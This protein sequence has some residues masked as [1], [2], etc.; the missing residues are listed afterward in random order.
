[1]QCVSTSGMGLLHAATAAAKPVSARG[2][3][4]RGSTGADD[5]TTAAVPGEAPPSKLRAARGCSTIRPMAGIGGNATSTFVMGLVFTLGGVGASALGAYQITHLAPSEGV[6]DAIVY[7][8]VPCVGVAMIAGGVGH[9]RLS[10]QIAKKG[11]DDSDAA[12]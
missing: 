8:I 5:D 10:R 11:L 6:A 12:S 7:L 4:R 9:F 2:R 1:M 3:I